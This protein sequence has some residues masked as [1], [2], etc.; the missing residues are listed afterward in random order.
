MKINHHLPLLIA[1]ISFGMACKHQPQFKKGILAEEFIYDSASFPS[2]HAATIAET[3]AGLVVAFFGGT[4]ERHPDVCIFVSRQEDGK[5][6]APEEAANGIINDTLRYPTWNPVLFQV[7]GDEL[8]LFYKT[9]PRPSS[10]QGMMVRSK[11]N[12]KTWSSPDSLPDGYIGPVKNKPLLLS[13]GTLLCP[14]ST[15]GSGWKIHFEY[16]KDYGKTWNKSEPINDGK[17]YNAIQP[18]LLEHKDGRLQLLCRSRNAMILE[19]WSGDNGKTWSLLKESSLPNNNSGIDAV[20][21][22]NGRH[23]LVYNHIKTPANAPKG[24]RTPLNVAVSNDGKKWHAALVL[25]DSE[26]GQYSYPSVIRS[27]DG[28]AHV[29]YTWRREKIKYVKINPKQFTTKKIKNEQWPKK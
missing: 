24:Y 2:C 13:D 18:T 11:D 26:I 4:R 27:A 29:V 5:W 14:S 25:E 6:T 8:L 7:P 19:S 22:A 12:G 16:T 1:V 15:E 3:P 10:W 21:L 28:M 9:G 23:L 17:I 20:T